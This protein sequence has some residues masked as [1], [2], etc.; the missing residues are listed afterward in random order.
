MRIIVARCSVPQ[1][2]KGFDMLKSRLPPSDPRDGISF[3]VK[4]GGLENCFFDP[5]EPGFIVNR[6]IDEKIRLAPTL[7]VHIGWVPRQAEHIQDTAEV[8]DP[9]DEILDPRDDLN[10][11]PDRTISAIEL[12]AL[13]TPRRTSPTHTKIV[14][15]GNMINTMLKATL[16]A[17]CGF[18]MIGCGVL[19]IMA[20]RKAL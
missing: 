10:E 16:G 1:Q 5:D 15:Y 7:A 2:T 14:R 9:Q 6:V 13:E 19:I 18:A 8:L 20:I 3:A 4:N 11:I 17:L 12:A